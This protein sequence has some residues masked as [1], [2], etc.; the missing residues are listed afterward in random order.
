[1]PTHPR[2]SIGELLDI[3]PD[4][5]LMIDGRGRI[6]YCNPAVRSLFGYA[7]SELDEQPLSVL[8]PPALRERHEHLLARFR[9]DGV[10]TMMGARP[11]LSACHRDGH[12]VPVSISIC[13]LTIEGGE[14]VS[15]AVVHNI[16]ALSSHLDRATELAETDAL[17]GLGNRLRL[18]H[19]MQAMLAGERRFAVLFLDLRNFKPFNDQ[20]GH[21]AGDEALRVV[22]KRLQSQ[23][24][25]E[26]LVVRLGGDE[27]V[28]LIDGLDDEQQLAERVQAIQASIARPL[29]IAQARGVLGV[30]IGAAIRPRH[31]QTERELLAAADQAMYQA[32]QAGQAYRLAAV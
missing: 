29:R 30:N 6:I 13:N 16:S 12:L 31:G 10:P 26:D 9:Q 4:A 8:L 22:G 20:F 25:D 28:V 24:R 15:V 14:R 7:P 32:K 1:M 18:A 2:T 11:V 17:T 5:V 23:V 21:E 27:F 3:L 19:R